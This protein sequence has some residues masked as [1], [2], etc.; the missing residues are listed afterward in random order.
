MGGLRGTGQQPSKPAG[1]FK[2]TEVKWPF[3]PAPFLKGQSHNWDQPLLLHSNCSRHFR[4]RKAPHA[5]PPIK[6]LLGF[7][8]VVVL[9]K[10]MRRTHNSE[11]T[12]LPSDTS[13]LSDSL[14][15]TQKGGAHSWFLGAGRCQT[16]FYMALRHFCTWY[17]EPKP[18]G[19]QIFQVVSIPSAPHPVNYNRKTKIK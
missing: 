17:S 5:S 11:P 7:R 10:F 6:Y 16:P 1:L 12:V 4:A 15:Q 9:G 3:T 18:K 19:F 14:E 13:F 2:L 8:T